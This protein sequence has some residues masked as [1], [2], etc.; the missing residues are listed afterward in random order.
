M[1]QGHTIGRYASMEGEGEHGGWINGPIGAE[2]QPGVARGANAMAA[3]PAS[4]DELGGRVYLGTTA[5]VSKTGRFR[6]LALAQWTDNQRGR[7]LAQVASLAQL[8]GHGDDHAGGHGAH[9]EPPHTFTAS[10]DADPDRN[11]FTRVNDTLLTATS[12]DVAIPRGSR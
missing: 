3:L 8:S 4:E 10:F 12:L 1:G 11:A 7:E 6:R 2:G 5:G 9:N